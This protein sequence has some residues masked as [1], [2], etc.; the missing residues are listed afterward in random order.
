MRR[1]DVRKN[2]VPLSG[3]RRAT[4]LQP[5][6]DHRRAQWSS[7]PYQS[8]RMR[9]PDAA[10]HSVAA[11]KLARNPTADRPRAM[12]TIRV[13]IAAAAGPARNAGGCGT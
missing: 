2:A 6:P 13:P 8:G 9:P 4:I 10:L 1:T 7:L 3:A 5:L 11:A 12:T